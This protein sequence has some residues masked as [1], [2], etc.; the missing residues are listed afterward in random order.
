MKCC[1]ITTCDISENVIQRAFLSVVNIQLLLV[2]KVWSI[3]H[4]IYSLLEYVFLIW[5]MSVKLEGTK[6]YEVSRVMQIPF[7]KKRPWRSVN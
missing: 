2:N 5:D 7:I 6:G 1:V 4:K 3:S